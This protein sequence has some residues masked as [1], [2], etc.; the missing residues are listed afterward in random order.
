MDKA[1][2]TAMSGASRAMFQQQQHAANLANVNTTG[3]KADFAQ[4]LARNVEGEG[5]PTR[6]FTE[7]SGTWSDVSS[8]PLH[9]TGNPLDVAI[10]G[11]GWLTVLDASGEEAYTRSGALR[12]NQAG[13]LITSGGRP[14]VDQGGGPVAVPEYEQLQ[15]GPDG[16]ISILGA[17]DP[18]TQPVAVGQL[19]LVRGEQ[20]LVKG[21]DGL[22]RAANNEPLPASTEVEMVSNTLESSNV[23]AVQEMVAFMSL[24]RQFEMQLKT[25]E[26]AR[27]MAESGDRLIRD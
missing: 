17:G 20:P 13:Q 23:N 8:G 10:Q 19:K 27:Q 14:V 16:T 21:T 7:T 5:L 25:L 11:E 24:G 1:I 3:F 9:R 4:I 2:Y 26:T 15:I 18:K 6:V 22:F 12:I